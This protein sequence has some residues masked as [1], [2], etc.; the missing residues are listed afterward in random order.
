M[1]PSW[2][3]ASAAT[4]ARRHRR[5]GGHHGERREGLAGVERHH[6]PPRIWPLRARPCPVL[7]S[8]SWASR[9][10][11]SLVIGRCSG[12]MAATSSHL[13]DAEAC[14]LTGPAER[15]VGRHGVGKRRRHPRAA[16][17]PLALGNPPAPRRTATA[18]WARRGRH[19]ALFQRHRRRRMIW[20]SFT[21]SIAWAPCAW[22]AL[23]TDRADRRTTTTSPAAAAGGASRTPRAPRRRPAPGGPG[24][25]A[26]DPVGARSPAP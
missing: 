22:R 5:G 1:A 9:R 3:A 2:K 7:C 26:H 12:G 16:R 23:S 25:R 24:G 4:T 20:T 13:G 15:R 18:T 17:R 10:C 19:P 14:A 6:A 11:S 21:G 8:S